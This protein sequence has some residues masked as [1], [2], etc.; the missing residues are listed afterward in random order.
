MNFFEEKYIELLREK[1]KRGK[2][3]KLAR[4]AFRLATHSKWQPLRDS[5]D[6]AKSY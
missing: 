3:S 6:K 1:E 2:L 4:P 5:I